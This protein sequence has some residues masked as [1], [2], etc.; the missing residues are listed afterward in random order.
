MP[1]SWKI[2][3]ARRPC[4]PKPGEDGDALLLARHREH[5]PSGAIA[6]TGDEVVEDQLQGAAGQ[7]QHEI[8]VDRLEP[9]DDRAAPRFEGFAHLATFTLISLIQYMKHSAEVRS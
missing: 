7:V 6:R 3:T 8:G 5:R 2:R 9:V 4:K 1:L